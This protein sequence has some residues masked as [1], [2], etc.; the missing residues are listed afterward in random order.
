MR[1]NRSL[2]SL[3]LAASVAQ[4]AFGADDVFVAPATRFTPVVEKPNLAAHDEGYIEPGTL[5]L[6]HN[7]TLEGLMHR[8]TQGYR[9]VNN[10]VEKT[11]VKD[12]NGNG[13]T[14]FDWGQSLLTEAAARFTQCLEQR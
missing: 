12:G 10:G 3:L 14:R 8:E 2:L 1:I 9:V 4:S 5:R 7:L 11:Y 13:P 6:S